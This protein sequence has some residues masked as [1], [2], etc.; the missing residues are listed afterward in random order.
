VATVLDDRLW[1]SLP[2]LAIRHLPRN[3]LSMMSCSARFSSCKSLVLAPFS[4]QIIATALLLLLFLCFIAQTAVLMA[5]R[6]LWE[7][8]V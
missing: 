3:L 7:A 1:F 4:P 6:R 8:I 5:N 2:G